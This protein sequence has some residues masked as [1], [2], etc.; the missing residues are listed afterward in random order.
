MTKSPWLDA[1]ASRNFDPKTMTREEKIVAVSMVFTEMV[2]R[3]LVSAALIVLVSFVLVKWWNWL[4]LPVFPALPAVSLLQMFCL[5]TFALAFLHVTKYPEPDSEDKPKPTLQ[6][7]WHRIGASLGT[8]LM[9]LFLGWV[10][11][12][13]IA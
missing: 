1:I 2:V 12:L 9:F 5:R 11:S 4:I 7:K 6:Q 10:V 3:F 8:W 13:I